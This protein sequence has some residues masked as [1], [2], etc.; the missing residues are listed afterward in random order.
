MTLWGL[1]SRSRPRAKVIIQDL[2]KHN[3]GWDEPIELLHL[4]ESWLTWVGELT[5]LTKLQ[6]PRAYTPA[7]S[8][9]P[10]AIRELHVFSDAS[11]R[12]YGSVAYLRTK[13]DQGQV[14]LTFVLAKSRVAPRKY[15]SIPRLELCA[16]LTG[17]QLGKVI[18]TELTIPV[19]KVTFWSDST[20]VLYWLTSE[21]CRYKVFVGTR[22]AEIHTLTEMAEW[23]YVESSHNPA[24]HIT[25]GLRLTELAGPHQWRSGPAFLIQSPD[26]WPS[27]PKTEEEADCN[28]LKKAAFIGTVTVLSS[29]IP[30]PSQFHTWQELVQATVRSLHGAA[31]TDPDFPTE[32]SEYI[33]AGKLLLAQ[34]QLD[35]FP[36]EV[37]HLKAGHPVPQNSR[38][39]D[40]KGYVFG[41]GCVFV[42]F[43][44]FLR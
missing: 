8:D 1:L 4:R 36:I 28:E 29:S 41:L 44:L 20:T 39:Y 23:R 24:D 12:S 16:A 9:N 35:S 19:H 5:T 17:T 6:F 26:Q 18:Q 32:A 33:E 43:H 3:L 38:C 13:D 2:W 40:S 27:L 15:L 42:L 37:R 21:S 34:A 10:S 14:I 22:V 25:R 11:E 30:D 7:T 31:T